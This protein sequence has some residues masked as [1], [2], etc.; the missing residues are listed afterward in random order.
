MKIIAIKTN[1][2]YLISDNLNNKVYFN[3]SLS[4][5][6]F[7][8]V[9]PQKTFKSDWFK[10]INKPVKIEKEVI[11][12]PINKRWELKSEFN[13]ENFK[14][15][16]LYHETLGEDSDTI[17]EFQNIKGLYEYKED[18][19]SNVL[20]QIE[21]EWD[22][23]L[24]IEI[25]NK[26]EGFNFKVVGERGHKLYSNVTEKN[27]KYD[28]L[29]EV[30]TPSILLHT[31]PC[32]LTSKET[33]DIIRAFIKDNIN[34]RVAVITN[35]YNFCFTVQKKVPLSKPYSRQINVNNS[36]F[37]KKKKKPIYETR[38]VTEKSVQIFEMTWKGYKG[39]SG[40]DGYTCIEPF[41]AENQEALKEYIDKYLETLI[42][43]INE[44]ISECDK[45]NGIGVLYNTVKV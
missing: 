2:G 12:Q 17:E 37:N 13:N 3:S 31:Q 14:K 29:T 38:F 25:F 44:P 35:D 28:I 40:Y 39:N 33:Y 7:D 18:K 4:N 27:L 43:A 15:I 21:F 24:Q 5:L 26:P 22:E 19:R 1:D 36:I 30:I 20:Q 16:W 11:Q 9:Y 34:P 42:S 10:I 45:C 41:E 6:L 32:K 8:N 23:I